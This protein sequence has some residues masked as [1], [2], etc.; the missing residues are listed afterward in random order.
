VDSGRVL[1]GGDKGSSQ[2]GQG[3]WGLLLSGGKERKG[4][5]RNHITFC[6]FWGDDKWKVGEK[7]RGKRGDPLTLSETGKK[8]QALGEKKETVLD[9]MKRP[10]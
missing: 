9:L 4:R 3:D 8:F 10:E 7:R 2:G 5:T 1:K 6:A